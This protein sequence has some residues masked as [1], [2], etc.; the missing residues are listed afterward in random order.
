MHHSKQ[1]KIDDTELLEDVR[2]YPDAYQYERAKCLGCS[3]SGIFFTL[4]HLG[5]TYKK[6]LKPLKVCPKMRDTFQKSIKKLKIAGRN[7][8]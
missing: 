4:W 8:I 1:Q 5:I 3:T 7:L 6:M 2:L